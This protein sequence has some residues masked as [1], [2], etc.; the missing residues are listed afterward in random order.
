ME[1]TDLDLYTSAY[2]VSMSNVELHDYFRSEHFENLFS[3]KDE[4][5]VRHIF[6]K[7]SDLVKLNILAKAL[8]YQYSKKMTYSRA[9]RV[10]LNKVF[11]DLNIIGDK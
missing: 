4:A 2:K 11:S 10:V 1:D 5:S 6:F 8:Q 3:S 7:R 9:L